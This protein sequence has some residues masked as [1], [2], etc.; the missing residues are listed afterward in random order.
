VQFQISHVSMLARPWFPLW[1]A[2]AGHQF[3]A[4]ALSLRPEGSGEVT[5]RSADPLAPPRVRLGLLGTAADRRMARELL[6]LTRR[7]F[8]TEPAAHLV[9]A[10]LLPGPAVRTDAEMD[11]YIRGM[12]QTG[13]HPSGTCAMGVGERAVLDAALKVR[14]LAALRVVDAA[15]FPDV[16]SGNTNAPAIM[17]AEKA[18][19][20]ILN[21]PP[22]C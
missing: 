10:E 9:S 22:L 7:F 17:L 16:P 13:M 8:A 11:A 6:K 4:T 5:L 15:A 21:R 3:T 18:S 1:R 14:G 19:D 20:L 2:G 12:I